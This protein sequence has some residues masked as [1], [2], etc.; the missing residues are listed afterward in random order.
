[1][2]IKKKMSHKETEIWLNGTPIAM[3]LQN[4]KFDPAVEAL[5][6]SQDIETEEEGVY[7]EALRRLKVRQLSIGQTKKREK[8]NG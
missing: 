6:P 7:Y 5:K 4:L 2:T 8:K 1:M 3:D